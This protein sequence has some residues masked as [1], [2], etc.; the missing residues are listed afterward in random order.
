MT[1]LKIQENNSQA[2]GHLPTKDCLFPRSGKQSEQMRRE[3][4]EALKV[5][6]V[7]SKGQ[8]V[9]QQKQTI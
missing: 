3:D 9:T 2:V 1:Q 5:Q 8:H 7:R 6:E 4:V